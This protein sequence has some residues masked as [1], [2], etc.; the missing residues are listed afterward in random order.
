MLE[1]W[2]VGN[3]QNCSLLLQTCE[4]SGANESEECT[5]LFALFDLTDSSVGII[6]IIISLII[7]CI[8][9]LLMVKMLTSLLEGAVAVVIKKVINPEF[10]SPIFNYLYGYLNIVIGA[11]L[12]FIVQSSSVFT[13]T[14]TPLVG[15]GLITV[16]CYLEDIA[17][18]GLQSKIHAG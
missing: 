8:S 3:C 16:R 13:S 10:R 11:L 5:Y 15:M 2:A 1:E 7:L 4:E 12:T 9:L 6:L 17:R 18:K 14:L